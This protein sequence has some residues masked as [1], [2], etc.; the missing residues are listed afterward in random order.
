MKATTVTRSR[1]H[2]DSPSCGLS[3]RVRHRRNGAT[4]A[5]EVYGAGARRATAPDGRNP[6]NCGSRRC[7]QTKSPKRRV[8]SP[9]LTIR[10]GAAVSEDLLV[11]LG[12]PVHPSM[13]RRTGP[14]ARG[15]TAESHP[16]RTPDRPLVTIRSR[17]IAPS[18]ASFPVA[19]TGLAT[20]LRG[21]RSRGA[22]PA[23]RARRGSP[24][25]QPGAPSASEGGA[26]RPVSSA[27]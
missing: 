8:A 24:C 22:L 20:S 11:P 16:S 9:V 7:S 18:S 6:R 12:A 5:H 19:Y 3:P 10:G 14:P 1:P 13:P 4:Q 23:S 2:G 26:P 27:A 17:T 15:L 21:V 25:A